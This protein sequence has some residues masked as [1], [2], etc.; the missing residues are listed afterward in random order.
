MA[1]RMSDKQKEELI[2]EAV[3]RI[4]E[5]LKKNKPYLFL[6]EDHIQKKMQHGVI[7]LQIRVHNGKVTD[8]FLEDTRRFIFTEK[9]P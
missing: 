9:K 8:V 2:Q 6:I 5:Y 4:G 3:K 7:A 1:T